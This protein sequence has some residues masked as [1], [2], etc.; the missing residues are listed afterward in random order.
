MGTRFACTQESSA[1]EATKRYLLSVNDTGTR[2]VAKSVSPTRMVR[3]SYC[4]EIMEMERAGASRE[5]LAEYIGRGR[6]RM[7]LMEG[8]LTEGE[9][10]VGQ[11][12]AALDDLPSATDVVREL[13]AVCAERLS[14]M[15]EGGRA[16]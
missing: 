3:N 2:L 5:S 16:E 7:G 4:E 14:A 11:I 9:I 10:E 1:N 15:R 12:V 8:N 13:G 6:T